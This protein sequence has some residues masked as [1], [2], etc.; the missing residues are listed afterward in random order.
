MKQSAQKRQMKRK[1]FTSKKPS[2]TQSC[3]IVSVCNH[4][5]GHV[6]DA[7]GVEIIKCIC[8][9]LRTGW[10]INYVLDAQDDAQ[11]DPNEPEKIWTRKRRYPYPLR[12]KRM[13]RV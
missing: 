7:H 12:F 6:F 9:N 10:A 2:K 13:E 4:S 11:V 8:A 3:S 1:F 5:Y